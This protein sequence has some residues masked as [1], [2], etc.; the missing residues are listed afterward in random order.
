MVSTTNPLPRTAATLLML[1][2]GVIAPKST[3]NFETACVIDEDVEMHPF[4]FRAHAH[5]HGKV[6]SGWKVTHQE[7]G[8]DKWELIGKQD[9]MKPQMFYPVQDASMVIHNGDIVAARCHMTNDGDEPVYIGSTGDDEM[10]NFYM[11][12]WVEGTQ[13]LSDNT[14][15]SPGPPEYFWAKEGGLNNLPEKEA[16][17]L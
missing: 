2:D 5:K 16:N 10:C 17:E 4:A 1:T 15:L 11:M 7:D 6:V 9:P 12:Y 13:T 8:K 3:E 14:C